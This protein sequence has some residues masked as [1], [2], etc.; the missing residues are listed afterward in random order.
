MLAQSRDDAWRR[1]SRGF[2]RLLRPGLA[3][4]LSVNF[5]VAASNRLFSRLSHKMLPN[6]LHKVP[7]LRVPGD[8]PSRSFCSSTLMSG[9]K[10]T[11]E[12]TSRGWRYASLGEDLKGGSSTSLCLGKA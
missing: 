7:H 1:A 8:S 2:V 4:P 3:S 12:Y 10:G 6:P 11:R 9:R 5:Q